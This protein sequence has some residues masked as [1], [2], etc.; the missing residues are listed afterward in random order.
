MDLDSS[1]F[2][3]SSIETQMTPAPHTVSVTSSSNAEE[4]TGSPVSTAPERQNCLSYTYHNISATIGPSGSYEVEPAEHVGLQS[5]P[6]LL[7]AEA[8]ESDATPPAQ[9]YLPQQVSPLT[10]L[11][12][13]S[14]ADASGCVHIIFRALGSGPAAAPPV[15]ATPVTLPSS[16][17]PGTTEDSA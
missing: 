15:H 7:P 13:G 5:T 10:P 6:L 2:I 12:L 8:A 14:A 3:A 1:W 11:D 4:L 17:D 16:T 9:Q